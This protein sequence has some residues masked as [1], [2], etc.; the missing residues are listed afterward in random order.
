[1]T[2]KGLAVVEPQGRDIAQAAPLGESQIQLIK[3]TYCRG[4]TD[5][6]LQ[7]FIQ[8]CDRTGL[9]PFARQIFAVKRWDS[10]LSREVMSTQVSIDGFRLIA[11]RSGK[12]QGQVGPFWCGPDGQWVDVW[13]KNEAPAAAKVGVYRAGANE[14]IFAVALWREYVQTKKGGAITHMWQ[15]FGTV[16]L[17]KCAESQA[18]RKAF[19]QE[20]SGLYTKEEMSQAEPDHEPTQA[21]PQQQAPAQNPPRQQQPQQSQPAQQPRQSQAPSQLTTDTRGTGPSSGSPR[22]QQSQPAQQQAP[23]QQQQAQAPAR[24]WDAL[25]TGVR[26]PVRLSEGNL[27]VDGNKT[28]YS[29]I[30][31]TEDGKSA[32]IWCWRKS[33][34]VAATHRDDPEHFTGMVDVV[35]DEQTNAQN[36][37]TYFVVEAMTPHIDAPEGYDMPAAA[38]LELGPPLDMDSNP[39]GQQ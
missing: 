25:P 31:T 4:A 15:K 6:E 35:L 8:A 19:P 10:K 20:L 29:W 33:Q 1:M 14:P 36:G 27:Q 11:E 21:Q 18:L 30:A 34:P 32:R 39:I 12:Y 38:D 7:L 16:M 24:Q 3:D 13:L 9:D 22:P 2:E 23:A 5:D 37:K 28:Q 26:T 17:A